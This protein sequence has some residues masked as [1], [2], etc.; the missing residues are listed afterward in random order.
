MSVHEETH[1]DF[2]ESCLALVCLMPSMDSSL[3]RNST[4][5]HSE[6]LGKFL[7]PDGTRHEN[8]PVIVIPEAGV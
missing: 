6:P 3:V 2:S 8:T 4:Q 1:N 5:A 7:G